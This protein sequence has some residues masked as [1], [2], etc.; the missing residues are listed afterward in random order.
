MLFYDR[1]NFFINIVKPFI[2]YVIR[3][4]TK[5]KKSYGKNNN[6]LPE[7]SSYSFRLLFSSTIFSW[8]IYF[9]WTGV[10]RSVISWNGGICT[11][12]AFTR[13]TVILPWAVSAAHSYSIALRRS[14]NSLSLSHNNPELLTG[15]WHSCISPQGSRFVSEFPNYCTSTLPDHFRN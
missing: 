9:T 3:T 5:T 10:C 1:L 4:K 13:L 2:T 7:S 15:S 12:F 14:C 11:Y 6:Y 8:M